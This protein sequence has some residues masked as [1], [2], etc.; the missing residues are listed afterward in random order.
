MWGIRDLVL[1]AVLFGLTIVQDWGWVL[2]M[3]RITVAAGSILSDNQKKVVLLASAGLLMTLADLV[4]ASALIICTPIPIST[5]IFEALISA[6]WEFFLP[7]AINRF[8]VSH[9]QPHFLLLACISSLKVYAWV[10]TRA[11]R[12]RQL[13]LHYTQEEAAAIKQEV[14]SLL[15][16]AAPS[17]STSRRSSVESRQ[18]LSKL[19]L[20]VPPKSPVRRLSSRG[21][22]VLQ[23]RSSSNADGDSLSLPSFEMSLSKGP[24]DSL[25]NFPGNES[26]I[27]SH[28][29][30]DLTREEVDSLISAIL[31]QEYL[32]WTHKHRKESSEQYSIALASLLQTAASLP[33][34]SQSEFNPEVKASIPLRV[35][36]EENEELADV[37][38][39]SGEWNFNT[40]ELVKCTKEPL[41]EVAYYLFSTHTIQE[42]F[43]IRREAL[44][45]FLRAVESHYS[46]ANYY[47]NSLHAADVLNSVVFLL[48]SGLHRCGHF[49]D[50]EV[51]ALLIA[52]LAH[53]I[54]HPGVNNSFLINKSDPLALLY[55][56]KS[57]LEMMHAST[58]FFLLR[59]TDCNI[60]SALKMADAVYVRRV[61]TALILATDLQK[62]FS[63]QADYRYML[64]EQGKTLADEE[65]RLRTLEI[66]IKCADLAHGAKD[67]RIHRHW[68]DLITQEFFSQG[69]KER[70]LGLPVSPLC[71]RDSVSVPTSQIAFLTVMVKPLYLLWEEL[72]RKTGEWE[73]SLPFELC[74]QLLNVNVL[75]WE[76]Q[77]KGEADVPYVFEFTQPPFESLRGL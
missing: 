32:L 75:Y 49:L 18:L 38:L 69:D 51:F 22:I 55:N 1:V 66:C 64:E 4:L 16:R 53:D 72:L 24:E 13:T 37:M 31:R 73:E 70:A 60:L 30:P 61:V 35:L 12:E 15:R 2:G 7:V 43:S 57:V 76:E 6:A 10:L 23:R 50:I 29:S 34:G 65:F 19:K 59:K 71:D 33:R 46:T 26:S 52:A 40:L 25:S 28:S 5:D 62:H 20:L 9:S 36:I 39:H 44:L 27:S 11:L 54:S 47:H 42:K 74:I 17:H 41:R 56:D 8:T 68:T 21:S 58:L 77:V 48:S 45:G 67:I 14:S 63:M 3:L